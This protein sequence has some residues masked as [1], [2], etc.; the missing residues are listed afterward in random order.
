MKG[1]KTRLEPN[2]KQRTFFNRCAGTSRYVY[3]WGLAEWKRQYEAWKLDN[4]L[5]KPSRY[6]LCVR[7][8]ALKDEL[9][10]WVREVPYAVTESA[11]ESLGRAFDNF[12]RNIKQGKTPGY[13]KFKNR[14]M[15]RKFR[16]RGVKPDTDR[17]YIPILGDVRLSQNDYIPIG[18][19]YGIYASL[20]ER[21]GHWYVSI[22]VKDDEDLETEL[23]RK[24]LGVDFGIKTLATI[25]NGKIFDNPK[26]LN[27]ADAKLKRLQRELSRRTRGGANYAKT[28]IK[29]AR[30]HAKVADVRS[31]TLH[32]VSDY[33][34]AKC[35]PDA[36]VIE[37]LNVSGMLSNHKLARAVSDVGFNELRS[38][39]EYKAKRYGIEVIVAYWLFPSSKTCHNC[40][41]IKSD[42]KLSDRIYIC[43]D[44]GFTLDR[45]LN[46][47][48]NLAAYGITA[49]RA[50]IACGAEVL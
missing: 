10:P 48:L 8:N 23:S 4:E 33:L 17:V 41:A 16:L 34:T 19:E 30:A 44:C 27:D 13:P 5:K 28:K 37:D 22:L 36:I 12:F 39:I 49:K 47:A 46:A 7:F 25:S 15:S 31:F 21:A 45:D 9:C 3:N 26:A 43:G 32:Q 35:K 42:L 1:Y 14:Y 18:S 38:Q 2:N 20:S 50:G 6:G 24:V 11:F 40:G 29:L